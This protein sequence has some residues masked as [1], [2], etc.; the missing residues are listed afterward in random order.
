MEVP[1]GENQSRQPHGSDYLLN[2]ALKALPIFAFVTDREGRIDSYYA[3][4]P[5]MLFVPPG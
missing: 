1:R 5:E 2:L 3:F 4:H